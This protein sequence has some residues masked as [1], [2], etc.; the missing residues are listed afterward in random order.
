[1]NFSERCMASIFAL[2]LHHKFYVLSLFYCLSLLNCTFAQ[3]QASH[4]VTIALP[5]MLSVRFGDTELLQPSLLLV[6]MPR[7]HLTTTQQLSIRTNGMWTLSASF[8]S[9][10]QDGLARASVRASQ[11]EIHTLRTYP[12]VILMGA[13][14]KGW[15]RVALESSLE[16]SVN[17]CQ[18]NLVYTLTQP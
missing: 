11:T 3:N 9:C 14:T 5:R 2:L 4:S 6:D 12:R 10:E 8:T 1:M 13:A 7:A 18:G 15:E 17:S 16:P